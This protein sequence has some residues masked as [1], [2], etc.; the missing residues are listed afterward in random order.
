MNLLIRDSLLYPTL[1]V[2]L[3]SD[4]LRTYMRNLLIRNEQKG[5]LTDQFLQG[6]PLT[7]SISLNSLSFYLSSARSQFHSDL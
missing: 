1:I 7:S 3:S 4:S 5:A 6:L 2:F